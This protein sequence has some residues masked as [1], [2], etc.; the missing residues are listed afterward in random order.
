MEHE[1]LKVDAVY[2][3]SERQVRDIINHGSMPVNAKDRW[4][5]CGTKLNGFNKTDRCNPCRE[6]A[7]RKY[8]IC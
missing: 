4:C 5:G 3:A 2:H 8:M 6:K 1:T 7:E